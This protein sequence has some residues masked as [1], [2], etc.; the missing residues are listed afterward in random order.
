MNIS[1]DVNAALSEVPVNVAPL[2]SDSDFKT[3]Q[4]SVA[5]N[6]AGMA[7]A[8]HF[9]DSAGNY[10][11]T[12]VT[13]TT[14]G[15]YDWAHQG[16]GMYSIEIPASGGASINN[17]AA[18]Y[19]YFV[20][21]A[22]GVLAW[23]GPTICFRDS[24]LNDLLCDSAYSATR[25]LAGTAIPAVASGS[26]GALLIDGT[27]T[28]AISNSSGK[29]LLQATQTGVTIPTVTTVTNQLTAAQVAT[30]VW[31]DTTAG[32]F[33]VASSIGKS[34]YTTG[35]APGAASGL[36]IVGSNMGTVSSVTGN[37]GGNVV[38][39][40][41][42]VSGNVGG[43]VVGSVAS[44]S[45][46]VGG[47]VAGS[48]G[49]I[50][51][52]GIVASSFGTG[53]ITSTVIAADAIG[54]SELAADAI[55]EIQSGLSTLDAAAVAA[56]VWNAATATY[57]SAGS[58]GLLVETNLDAQVSD[59]PTNAELATALAT[60]DDATLAAI[61][62][63]NNLSSAQVTTAVTSALTTAL[64]EGYRGTNATGSVRDLLYELIAHA[65]EASISSTTKTL[66]KLDGTTTAKTYT[67]NDATTPTA[68][69]ETT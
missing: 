54:A 35:N 32:D 37:V 47:N 52:G 63:L 29:V 36:A 33:T 64:T 6:A 11:V 67:L 55:A 18:G 34:L 24:G 26:A 2:T 58:Y 65:G 31:Q 28:A 27:G 21:S 38:G 61:A 3:V 4:T 48:V 8:W 13:P 17:N 9:I 49:S 66:K 50:A 69:T 57:G 23:R 44:V 15:T 40:V 62:A 30:G 5:Y 53:A 16:G 14:A 12:S 43:N 20:G 59:V 19:G 25:G 1:M 60:A 42:S 68:I 46:S 41:A 10:T 39:S 7:L 51:T 22:T 56:A 45:G